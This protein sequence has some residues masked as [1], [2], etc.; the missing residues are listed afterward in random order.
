MT[1]SMLCKRKKTKSNFSSFLGGGQQRQQKR[2]I[3]GD[4]QNVKKNF[5]DLGKHFFAANRSL[6]SSEGGEN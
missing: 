2:L 3:R 1:A 6:Q 5:F 4:A